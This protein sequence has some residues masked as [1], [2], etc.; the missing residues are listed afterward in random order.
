M[1]ERRA[2]D[3][4]RLSAEEWTQLDALARPLAEKERENFDEHDEAV[5]L[6]LNLLARLDQPPAG[7]EVG[8]VVVHPSAPI[9]PE[10]LVYGLLDRI[11][12]TDTTGVVFIT[13]GET[14]DGRVLAH[15]PSWCVPQ[16]GWVSSLADIVKEH[17]MREMQG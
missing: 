10:L 5:L 9:T 11:R 17:V 13:C 12:E 14:E 8:K 6:C 4:S 2:P 15:E 3:H 7:A 16:I 1:S